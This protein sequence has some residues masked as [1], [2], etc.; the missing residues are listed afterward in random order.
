MLTSS[1]ISL[2]LSNNAFRIKGLK[3]LDVSQNKIR[4]LGSQLAVLKELKSLNV[5][6]NRLIAGSLAPVS[7]LSKLQT[8]SA[9]GNGLGAPVPRDPKHPQQTTPTALPPLP[10]SLKQIK[11]DG[12]A[13]ST[14]PPQIVQVKCLLKLEK[15][16]LSNNN[17]AA[18]P[19]E[20]ANLVALTE[21]HLDNNVIVGLPATIGQLKKLK[22]LSLKNNQL[23][24]GNTN[25]SE[26]NPQPMPA[27]LFSDTLLIDL[28]LHGNPMTR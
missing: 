27:A 12:N 1:T 4:K 24:A 6:Q 21:I 8:L 23:R 10:S 3:T 11:L 13:F 22:T 15:L 20:I 14:F 5:D 16:D 28:N 19:S 25:F 17:L 9:G 7:S 2:S 26:K 18:I